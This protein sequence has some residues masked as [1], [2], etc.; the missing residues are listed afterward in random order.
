MFHPKNVIFFF[1]LRGVYFAHYS[2]L[3]P[4]L[5]LPPPPLPLLGALSER[6]LLRDMDLYDGERRLRPPR[7]RLRLR[8][9]KN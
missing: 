7:S 5:D 2:D 3:E 4:D 1:A 8:D 9:L 6:D